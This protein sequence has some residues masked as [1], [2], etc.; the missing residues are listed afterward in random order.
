MNACVASKLRVC[1]AAKSG[2]A[3]SRS[4]I[5]PSNIWVDSKSIW[6]SS[7]SNSSAAAVTGAA[8]NS[9]GDGNSIS[10]AFEDKSSSNVS[11]GSACSASSSPGVRSGTNRLSSRNPSDDLRK[12]KAL[13]SAFV[14]LA[15]SSTHRPNACIPALAVV[16]NASLAGRWS[17]NHVFSSCSYDQAASPNSLSPTILELPLSV[18]K[19]RRKMVC[20]ARSEGSPAKAPIA[21]KPS[22]TT[23]RA[24]SKKMSR[25]SS[26]SPSSS[27]TGAI[28]ADGEGCTTAADTGCGVCNTGSTT[29]IALSTTGRACATTRSRPING[30]SSPNSSSYT[31]SFLASS[32]W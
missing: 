3:C 26:S 32:R 20:C 7:P 27:E 25:R 10:I 2:C 18:W 11:S 16:I 19:A 6:G 29:S 12:S 4:G 31:N 30:L 17:A 23:S 15:M 13:H 5:K 1:V 9:S 8:R 28:A 21:A 24:S 14:S 22:R